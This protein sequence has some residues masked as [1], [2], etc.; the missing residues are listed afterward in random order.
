MRERFADSFLFLAILNRQDQKHAAALNAMNS[1]RD[2]L[3]TSAWVLTEL[4]DGLCAVKSRV[5]FIDLE[6]R[7]RS[8]SRVTIIQPDQALYEAGLELYRQR[9]DK[10][11][12]LTDCISFVIMRQRGIAEA[13]TG[14]HHFEQAGFVALLK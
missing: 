2:P 1:S 3:V 11:W 4:A 14:D 10:S 5:F 6:T 13:F 7:L 8:D 12:S 9:V